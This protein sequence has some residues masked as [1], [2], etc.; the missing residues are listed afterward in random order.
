MVGLAYLGIQPIHRAETNPA[1][2]IVWLLWWPIL[3]FTGLMLGRLWC[4]LCPAGAL[5]DW[6]QTL[7]VRARPM[8]PTWIQQFGTWFAVVGIVA[9]GLAFLALG[10]ETD[11]GLTMLFIAFIS[12]GAV[13]L[14]LVFKERVW[15]RWFCPLGM[16]LGL[17]SRVGWLEIEPGIAGAKAAGTA[18]RNCPQFTSPISSQRRHHCIFCG[19]CLKKGDMVQVR[20][21]PWPIQAGRAPTL[22]LVQALAVNLL[23]GLLLVDSLRMTPFFPGYMA[24]ALAYVD[25]YRFALTLGGLAIMGLV[26]AAQVGYSRLAWPKGNAEQLFRQLSLTL[27]PLALAL[28]LALSTQHLV[29]A[30]PGVLQGIGTELGFLASGHMPPADA[31]G[32]SLSLK[33]F[34]LFLLVLGIAGAMYFSGNGKMAF[35]QRAR[36]L[37]PVAPGVMQGLIFLQPMSA[38]C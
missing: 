5:G 22:T 30:G 17:Y 35:G 27:I 10:L 26:L 4:A 38:V 28:H 7:L 21:N 18:A 12:V 15:C 20:F 19:L 1:T 14:A 31:Y 25:N 3:P 2:A 8:A 36:L 34:Q 32:V 24:W 11:G 9:I 13:S 6:A 37:A 29:S 33:A 16:M 23:W